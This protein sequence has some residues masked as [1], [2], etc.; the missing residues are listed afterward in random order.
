MTGEHKTLMSFLSKQD[1]G[2]VVYR[3][4]PL[5]MLQEEK[6]SIKNPRK[7]SVDSLQGMI[8]RYYKEN[9]YKFFRQIFKNK[10]SGDLY[11]RKNDSLTIVG[12]LDIESQILVSSQR[13][14]K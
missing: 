6:I 3:I 11:F 7:T 8:V 13:I 5:D 9:G 2:K 10:Y 4:N 12:I 14:D 1:I